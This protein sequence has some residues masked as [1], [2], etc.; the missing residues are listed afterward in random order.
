MHDAN[1]N[2]R[3]PI[4]RMVNYDLFVL[5]LSFTELGFLFLVWVISQASVDTRYFMLKHLE[6]NFKS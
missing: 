5:L 6:N 3:V 1:M 4:H 2:F